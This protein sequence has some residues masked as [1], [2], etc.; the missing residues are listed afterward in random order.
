MSPS[1][2]SKKTINF[3]LDTGITLAADAWGNPENKPV[4]LAHGAGQT[5]YAWGNTAKTL[6][7][8]GWY[9]IAIDLRGHG[10]SSWDAAGGYDVPD[11][12]AD[13]K[14]LAQQFKEKPAIVGASLGGI[15]S[16]FAQGHLDKN[17]F[18]AII[19]VDITP[20]M[21]AEGVHK[22]LSFM[23]AHIEEGFESLEE[24][25][26]AIATFLPERPRPKNLDG[27]S[28]NL[29]HCDD[30]RYRW[31]WDPNFMT[32]R[33]PNKVRDPEPYREAARSLKIPT[34]LVRGRM[35]NLVSEEAAKEFLDLVPHSEYFD[36]ENAGHMIAGDKNDIFSEAVTGFLNRL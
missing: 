12:A 19:L 10:E 27:L 5:R 36:V 21:A 30:G 26:D 14:S 34:L 29:R 32:S 16:L 33:D 35:S 25:A 24:A 1:V 31:H 11:I 17:L 7:E 6:A 4:I 15:S 2:P 22:V 13:L 9:A 8:Q 20:T 18:A 28:K 3:Q 23:S